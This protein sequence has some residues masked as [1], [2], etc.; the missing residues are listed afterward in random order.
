MPL[1]LIAISSLAGV[2]TG[3]IWEKET[4]KKVVEVANKTAESAPALT[5]WDKALMAGA[6]LAAFWI[7]KKVK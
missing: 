3:T 6:G 4:T 7:W 5:F 1:L 2:V